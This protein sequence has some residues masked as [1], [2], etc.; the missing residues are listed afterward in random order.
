MWGRPAEM[1]GGTM[2]HSCR[3]FRTFL[4][5]WGPWC[6][7]DSLPRHELKS[8]K[9]HSG[10]GE[11]SIMGRSLSYVIRRILRC[12]RAEVQWFMLEFAGPIYCYGLSDAEKQLQQLRSVKQLSWSWHQVCIMMIAWHLGGQDSS[13]NF[14][15]KGKRQDIG[16][17]C[18]G[19]SM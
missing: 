10:R 2:P 16:L 19:N 6:L 18:G 9:L 17:F 3:S 1:S 14:G 5:P 7:G 8:A 4:G 12:G 15:T 13:L 11:G